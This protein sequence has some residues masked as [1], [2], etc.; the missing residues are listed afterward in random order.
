MINHIKRGL[1]FVI[2]TS[3]FLIPFNA[4][5][6]TNFFEN[7]KKLF[8][9]KDYK[10]SKFLFHQDI[11]FNPK[12]YKSYLYLAKIF[13]MEE[14]V[15]EEEK[16]LNTTLLLDPS[17]EEATYMLIELKLSQSDFLK[18]KILKE[19]FYLICSKLC[20]KKKMIEETLENN[21]LLKSDLKNKKKSN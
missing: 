14:N 18:V 4:Y 6:S 15:Y 2:L 20:Y 7:G 10:K 16:N 19:K 8:N 11:V 5:T 21:T 13:K 12:N 1:L 17:N 9:N 3:I